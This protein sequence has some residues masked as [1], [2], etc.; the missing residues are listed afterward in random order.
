MKEKFTI[1]I[2]Y[3][4]KL[5]DSG[6]SMHKISD[7]LG[8]SFT[9]V[10]KELNSYEFNLNNPYKEIEGKDLIAVC[11]KTG[12]EFFDHDNRSGSITTHLLE[13]FPDLEIPSHYKRKDILYKTFKYWYHDYFDFIYRDIKSVKKCVY[14]D[15]ETE[16]I[17]N[18]SGAYMNHMINTHDIDIDKHLDQYPEDNIFFKNHIKNKNRENFL[19]KKENNIECKICG[20]KFKKITQTHLDKHNITLYEYREKYN[21]NNTKDYISKTSHDIILTNRKENFFPKK[22]YKRSK[23]ETEIINYINRFGFDIKIND[24]T[25]LG[26]LECDIVIKDLL[27]LIEYNGVYYH[28][29]IS[30]NKNKNYHRSKLLLA[31]SKGYKMIQIFEDEWL[32]K[33]DIIKIKLLHILGIN[34]TNKIYARK[35]EIIEINPSLKNNFLNKNHIQGEDRSNI[36][37]GAY[38]NNELISVMTFDNKR[39]FNKTKNHNKNIY[40]LKRFA[41]NNNYQ[42][43]GI[44]SK[45]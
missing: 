31:N 29:E 15:W 25:I 8:C 10:Q 21:L 2:E 32:F 7:I 40:E 12:K 9:K 30:G 22:I 17:N 33:K 28:S 37:L 36:L 5:F 38:Y 4:K 20:D 24:R 39:V 16:D 43:I 44:G 45:L 42:V 14:C 6:I 18:I 1:D 23:A 19:K 26:G 41:T 13:L 34:N 35:C 3:A 11:K 27:L